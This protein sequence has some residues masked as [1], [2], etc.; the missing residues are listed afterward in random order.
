MRPG[1]AVVGRGSVP[2]FDVGGGL[3]AWFTAD[4]VGLVLGERDAR[5]VVLVSGLGVCL[6]HGCDV[7]LL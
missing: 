3:V 1:D 5:L 4:R 6:V 2:A 7:V